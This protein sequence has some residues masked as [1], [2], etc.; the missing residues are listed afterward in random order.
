MHVT[1][2]KT[3]IEQKFLLENAFSDMCY[4]DTDG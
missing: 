2:L 4:S 1:T 3:R